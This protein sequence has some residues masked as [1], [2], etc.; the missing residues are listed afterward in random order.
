MRKQIQPPIE[1]T[2]QYTSDE[3]IEKDLTSLRLHRKKDIGRKGSTGKFT[4]YG[5]FKYLR[6]MPK[7]AALGDWVL[8]SCGV[9]YLKKI[10]AC[11][12]PSELTRCTNR[13]TIELRGSFAGKQALLRSF[14]D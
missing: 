13:Y 12:T 9:A 2:Y 5:I 1:I 14:Y 10:N 3:W 7:Y 11:P 6:L 4:I 8:F